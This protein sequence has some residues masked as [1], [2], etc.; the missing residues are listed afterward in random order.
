MKA[1][2]CDGCGLAVEGRPKIVGK[3]I[4][5]EY[6]PRCAAHGEAFLAQVA[7]RRQQMAREF[8]AER[9]RIAQEFLG[10]VHLKALPDW[11]PSDGS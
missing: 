9:D 8:T 4:Q 3:L 10:S 1:T 2:L 7:E 11:E 6:C 5:R